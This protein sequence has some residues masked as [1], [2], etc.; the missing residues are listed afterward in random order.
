MSD[1][2]HDDHH[3]DGHGEHEGAHE[4]DKM[5]NSRLFNLLFSLSALTLLACIGVVQ[6]FNRQV[7]QISDA[8][9]K[10]ASFQLQ[11]YRDEQAQI[12]GSWGRVIML[13]DD[14][15][16]TDRGGT[17]PREAERA[18]MPI[19]EARRR[20]LAD[21][22]LLAA[23]PKYPGWQDRDPAKQPV[24]GQPAAAPVQVRPGRPMP[25]AMPGGAPRGVR[26]QGGAPMPAERPAPGARPVPVPTEGKAPPKGAPADGKAPAEGKAPPAAPKKPAP[27]KPAEGKAPP[28]EG[29]APPAEGKAADAG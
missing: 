1:A 24:P 17:G 29:K 10:D 13:D 12:G 25:G 16:P 3:D 28:A 20:V 27:K 22:K 21:P 8:R 4:I 2:H 6:L 19:A 18:H 14:G 7:E 9:G 15:V 26:P 5:P 23:Q 11:A